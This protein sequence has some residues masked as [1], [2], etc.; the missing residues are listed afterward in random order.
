MKRGAE[1]QKVDLVQDGAITMVRVGGREIAI[2]SVARWK[3]Y[4]WGILHRLAALARHYG[5][6][7]L[8]S[9]AEGA[10]VLDIGANVGEFS[11]FA[12]S[13]GCI[14]HA[15]EPDPL[16]FQALSIN[17]GRA[18]FAAYRHALWNEDTEM[19]FYSSVAGADSSLIKP[20]H[21]GA[22]MKVQAVTLDHFT[23][24]Q[25]IDDIFFIK[26]DAE[27]GEPE[28][29]EGGAETLRRTRYIAI[30]CGPERMGRP[31]VEECRAILTDYGFKVRLLPSPRMILF[32]ENG[33]RR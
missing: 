30:D 8:L 27:G 1:L 15:I 18:G 24:T 11:M 6:E 7:E 31:T 13:R 16:N 28:V 20:D 29:L 10:T 14:A 12:T 22:V 9:N 33:S 19:T 17:S 5:A 26:A 2:T 25:G 21:V 4:R 32:G 3:L 23:A